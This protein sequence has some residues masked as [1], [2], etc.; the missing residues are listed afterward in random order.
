MC[1]TPVNASANERREL[2]D[3]V[4][5]ASRALVHLASRSL[6]PWEGDVTLPQLR[7]LVVL[8]SRG[9]QRPADL[10]EALGV[11]RPNATRMCD[12]LAQK[13][14]VCRSRSASDR[15]AVRIAATPDGRDLVGQVSAARRGELDRIVDLI[16]LRGRTELV[17][18]LRAFSLAAG[19]IPGG[20]WS[21]GWAE[22]CLAS[23]T[24]R[25]AP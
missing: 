21:L 13:K 8:C 4:M 24:G 6:G 9:P 17:G 22:E 25:R 12:R 11:T 7:A 15:R 20:G 5:H 3:A 14:L 18:A 10:A 19:E 23:E 16:P 2:V 1:P